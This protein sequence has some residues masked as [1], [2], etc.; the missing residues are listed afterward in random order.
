M[1]DRQNVEIPSHRSVWAA[2]ATDWSGD[3]EVDSEQCAMLADISAKNAKT[4]TTL[5]NTTKEVVRDIPG[6]YSHNTQTH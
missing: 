6:Y 5:M 4:T 1:T 2:S 3:G